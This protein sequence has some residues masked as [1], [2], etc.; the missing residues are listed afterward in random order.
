MESQFDL[1]QIHNRLWEKRKVLSTRIKAEKDKVDGNIVTNPDR[2]DLAH[3]YSF[4]ERQLSLLEQLECQLEEVNRALQRVEEDTYGQ[5]NQCGNF[6]LPERLEAL[7]HAE[8]CINCQRQN[9]Q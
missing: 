3:E 4:R 1:N 6:I 8:L 9:A 5:C 2:S 7:P